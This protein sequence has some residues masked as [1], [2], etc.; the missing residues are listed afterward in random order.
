ML[1]G[2]FA[3]LA[4][5]AAGLAVLQLGPDGD[6][7]TA[8]SAADAG[9]PA[10]E[11]GADGGATAGASPARPAAPT[12]DAGVRA[13]QAPDGGPAYLGDAPGR[14]RTTAGAGAADGGGPGSADGRA[15][16]GGSRADELQQLRSRVAA[17]EQQ[18][19]QARTEAQTDQL[20]QLNE[21]VA[22]LREQL[23]QEKARRQAEETAAQQARAQAQQAVTALSAA[24]QQLAQGN[25][26][27]LETLESAAS[28]L[29]AP[30]QRAVESARTAVQSG[31]LAAARYWL[32]V[33]I[34]QAQR[35]QLSR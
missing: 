25:S 8:S 23:A 14:M 26:R 30:S 2:L 33:A 5:A 19:A 31:D 27:V 1:K 6:G 16:D 21:Q 29:P 10:A 22:A 35:Q 13:P 32:S 7:D 11:A 15:N 28:A 12:V 20:K 4:G 17:L 18:L 34:A 3:G 9:A 24:E